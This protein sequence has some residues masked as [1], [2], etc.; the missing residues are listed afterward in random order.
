V[1][2]R[3]RLNL[4]GY[5]SRGVRSRQK[6]KTEKYGTSRVDV[7]SAEMGDFHQHVGDGKSTDRCHKTELYD[8]DP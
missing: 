4:H 1:L 3:L 5:E 6:A 8:N 7:R 2:L